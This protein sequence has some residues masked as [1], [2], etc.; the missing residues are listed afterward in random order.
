MRVLRPFSA[1]LLLLSVA[2]L[3]GCR[4]LP[5]S[6]PEI[7]ADAAA[8]SDHTLTLI[9]AQLQMHLRD[10][11][12][13]SQRFLDESGNDVFE[14]ALWQL[15][16]LQRRRGAPVDAW[17][18]VDVVI[19]YARARALERLRRYRESRDAYKRVA[20]SGSLLQEPAFEAQGIMGRF[21]EYADAPRRELDAEER[22]PWIEH[23]VEKWQG[24]AWEF[25][26]TS[27]ES[28][29][30]EEAE[31]WSMA[32]VEAVLEQQGIKQAIGSCRRLIE[33]H[34]SSKLY[35]SHLIRLGDLYAEAARRE[36]PLYGM[37]GR[38]LNAARYDSF[39]D[40]ALAAYELAREQRRASL[41]AVA[42]KK[43]EALLATHQGV[44]AGAR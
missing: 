22:L 41:R 5:E 37:A 4:S 27:Y 12:Y 19:E 13:H 9:V 28:L 32:R 42:N 11:T 24:I 25:R 30:L 36:S 6:P 29:A 35:A 17:A 1:A 14:V 40:R 18:N 44:T 23:R 43:I 33:R 7:P 2:V 39:L 15:D 10:D 26:G 20:L 3:P 8:G 21:S 31:A 34:R 38:R 16:R